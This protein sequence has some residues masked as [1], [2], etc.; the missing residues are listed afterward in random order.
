MLRPLLSYIKQHG[1]M[2]RWGTP[3]HLVVRKD[4]DPFV[5]CPA[6]LPE[7][8]VFK[9]IPPIEVWDWLQPWPTPVRR[10]RARKAQNT[11]DLIAGDAQEALEEQGAAPLKTE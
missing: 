5:R 7:M 9:G 2:Y 1:F 8:F 11:Q 4:M 6:D 10:I 3:F